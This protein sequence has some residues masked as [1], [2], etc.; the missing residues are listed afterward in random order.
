MTSLLFI[1]RAI[2]PSRHWRHRTTEKV[3][4]INASA[5]L[6]VNMTFL[7][8]Q[9]LQ[10]CCLAIVPQTDVRE[11]QKGWDRKWVGN[12]SDDRIRIEEIQ[13]PSNSG[14]TE[15]TD[16]YQHWSISR[17]YTGVL[18]LSS[19]FLHCRHRVGQIGSPLKGNQW[20]WLWP[21]ASSFSFR[22]QASGLRAKPRL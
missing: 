19:C 18:F 2:P 14:K 21:Q 3:E 10:C 11:Y 17:F 12:Q 5:R 16:V 15:S 7:S 13:K 6:Q 4:T 1:H 22:P 9:L 20:H 8:D